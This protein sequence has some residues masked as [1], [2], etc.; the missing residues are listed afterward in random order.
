[1]KIAI[2]TSEFNLNQVRK[3]AKLYK[4][5]IFEMFFHFHF[6][7]IEAQ[8]D[9]NFQKYSDKSTVLKRNYFLLVQSNMWPSVYLLVNKPYFTL[10]S[11]HSKINSLRCCQYISCDGTF[12][13]IAKM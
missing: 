6:I 8:N 2:P 9:E 12:P 4:N 5:A 3:V 1:L 7:N 13:V 10:N 11:K